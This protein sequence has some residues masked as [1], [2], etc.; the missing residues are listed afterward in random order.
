MSA[1]ITVDIWSDIAC[2]WCYIGKR[3]FE[4]AVDTFSEDAENP[5]VSV[6]F[7]SFE[8]A[9]DTP[10][11][12]DG[13]ERD[14]LASHKGLPPDQITQMLD[15]V[16]GLAQQV[17]LAY[18]FD[19]IKHTK[20]LKAHQLVH[21]ARAQGKEHELMER[22]MSAYF[23]EGRHVGRVDDLADLAAD[24]GL[25]RDAAIHALEQETYA[26]DVSADMAQATEYGI[27]GVPFFVFD[28][29]YGVSGAQEPETFGEV[30]REVVSR[31][32]EAA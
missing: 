24:V 27:N 23:V 17:G 28:S 4:R 10:V 30:L 26:A 25:D 8:L 13:N 21:F 7:H 5:P 2:P 15:H 16:T 18:D 32:G 9:P 22:L 20:T 29:A 1:P 14:F 11:D 6:R 31:R 19:S 3:R 12:F